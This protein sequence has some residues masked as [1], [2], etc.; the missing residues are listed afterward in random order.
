MYE[1]NRLCMRWIDYVWDESI[2]YEMN[3]ICMRWIEYVW[4]E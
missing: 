2:V 1:V 3:R 4:D